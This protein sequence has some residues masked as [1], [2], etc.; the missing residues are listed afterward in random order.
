MIEKTG[1]DLLHLDISSAL[2]LPSAAARGSITKGIKGSSLSDDNLMKKPEEVEVTDPQPKVNQQD[3]R[4]SRSAR[5]VDS[6]SRSDRAV[7]VPPS[8]K[9]VP[10]ATT[11]QKPK[12]IH[13]DPTK[14]EPIQIVQN[15]DKSYSFYVSNF[16][17][18]KL[19]FV[20]TIP[21]GNYLMASMQITW[22]I[23]TKLEFIQIKLTH[24]VLI[25]L[26]A[27]MWVFVVPANQ[28]TTWIYYF[29][30]HPSICL[31]V[32]Y[33]FVYNALLLMAQ[34]AFLGTLFKCIWLLPPTKLE[35]IRRIVQSSNKSY[36]FFVSIYVLE[37]IWMWQNFISLDRV[38]QSSN[39]IKLNSYCKTLIIHLT[40]FSQDHKLGYIHRTLF[41]RFDVHVFCSII[42]T[43]EIMWGYY[44]RICM[45]TWIF[46]KIKSLWIKHVY[47][48]LFLISSQEQKVWESH[49][50]FY[51]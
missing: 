27:C 19:E 39:A 28:S 32:W 38:L 14:P 24:W 5:D 4:V 35:F 41:S 3:G 1:K 51:Y 23:P 29:V 9:S 42:L 31:S 43:L 40:L 49:F 25:I 48:N 47:S 12:P 16:I 21:S 8:P 50:I 45:F 44:F 18:T 37:D 2:K 22:Y 30:N 15:G 7:D 33:T 26:T 13:F 46:A 20:L 6:G 36:S 10:I 34:H 11:T 17:L